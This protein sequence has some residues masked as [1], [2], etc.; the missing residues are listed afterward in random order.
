M[1]IVCALGTASVKRLY[2][3]WKGLTIETLMNVTSQ[4]HVVGH[5]VEHANHLGEDENAMTVCLEF[6]QKLVE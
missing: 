5:D 3:T 6:G 1:Q 4:A 2:K